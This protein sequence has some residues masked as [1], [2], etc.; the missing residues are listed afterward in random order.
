MR[1][2]HLLDG[3]SACQGPQVRVGDP[4]ELL[5]QRVQQLARNVQSFVGTD[6]AL[7]RE[8]AWTCRT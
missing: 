4:G 7:G 1:T 5:L 3:D 8:P 6:A 2:P